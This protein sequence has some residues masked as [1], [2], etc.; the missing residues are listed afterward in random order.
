MKI[1]P[2]LVY[3][4]RGLSYSNCVLNFSTRD[5]DCL[6]KQSPS[7]VAVL[8]T[9]CD[10]CTSFQVKSH[11]LVGWVDE[12]RGS[13]VWISVNAG[14]DRIRPVYGD[15]TGQLKARRCQRHPTRIASLF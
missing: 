15:S 8:A 3:D 4:N 10:G 2:Y 9:T 1:Q 13:N 12:V 14:A 7:D 6:Y 5:A 11:V